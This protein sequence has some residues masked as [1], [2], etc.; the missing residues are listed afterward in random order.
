MLFTNMLVIFNTNIL[1]ILECT[2][3]PIMY[4]TTIRIIVDDIMVLYTQL[5]IIYNASVTQLLVKI[6]TSTSGY[7]IPDSILLANTVLLMVI[8]NTNV[9]KIADKI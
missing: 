5:L 6:N 1:V 9:H 7:G 4:K 3:L 8:Y 2:E